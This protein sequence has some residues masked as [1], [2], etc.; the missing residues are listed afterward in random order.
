MKKLLFVLITLFCFFLIGC[1]EKQGNE[2]LESKSVDNKINLESKRD[3][4]KTN[5]E[6]EGNFDKKTQDVEQDGD[7]LDNEITKQELEKKSDEKSK[8]G[9]IYSLQK[10]YE[11]SIL[12]LDDLKHLNDIHYGNIDFNEEINKDTEQKIKNDY[13]YKLVND[14]IT[15]ESSTDAIS[16]IKYYG[17]YNGAYVVYISNGYVFDSGQPH[18]IMA[19]DS[20]SCIY[21]FECK[22]STILVWSEE[23]Y[24]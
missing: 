19:G 4:E 23:V 6:Q 13:L 5:Q 20:S 24:E 16:I 10:A 21:V 17:K 1:N 7:E 2:K 22:Y 3:L 18:Y 8:V 12:S 9:R 11:L 15:I 14:G